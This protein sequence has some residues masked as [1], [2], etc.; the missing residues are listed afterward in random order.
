MLYFVSAELALGYWLFAFLCVLGALQWVA[1][2]YRLGGLAFLESRAG[3]YVLAAL[4]VVVGTAGF[5]LS[6][7]GPIFAPGP[8]GS[9]L[10][11]LF[12]TAA[13]CALVLAVIL[14]P[15]LA[16]GRRGV[17][18]FPG[19]DDGQ[20]V[21][22]GRA[23]ARLYLPPGQTTLA[24]AVCLLP[25]CPVGAA[26]T[27]PAD[28]AG[29]A[30]FAGRGGQAQP[31]RTAEARS[32]SILAR[33]LAAEGMVALV[34]NPDEQ[35]YAY[36]ATLATLPAAVA[37]LRERSEVDPERIGALGED[38]GGDLVIRAVSTSREIKAV[39]A[40]A[41][42][43]AHVPPGLG[44]LSEMSYVQALRWARDRRRASLCKELSA[45]EYGAR[46]PPRP[47]LLLYGEDDR[48]AGDI[49]TAAPGLAG[50]GQL[51]VI[52]GLG[53]L[54][55]ASHPLAMQIVSQWLKEHL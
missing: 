55:L 27:L 33:H 40:L 10:A 2:R 28:L 11:V 39:V 54:N 21:T 29:P 4:L 25:A 44:L 14:A 5:F 20:P 48:L 19:D 18:V 36:P 30:A 13:I 24:P 46:I 38:L 26:L 15:V 9:E 7:W 31:A 22:I 37:L 34:V 23:T 16:R 47:F 1:V 41:P 17:V 52:P 12:G 45:V 49:A 32:M 6:Q 43:L 3:G 50:S 35:S 8:A 42:I 53:H 51:Q